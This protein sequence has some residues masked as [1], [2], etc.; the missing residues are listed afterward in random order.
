MSEYKAIESAFITCNSNGETG[1]YNV[2][3]K[4]NTLKEAQQV[5]REIIDIINEPDDEWISIDDR[6]PDKCGHN[7]FS[8]CVLAYIKDN[9]CQYTAYYDHQNE[10]WKCFNSGKDIYGGTITHWKPLP[11]PPK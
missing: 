11:E 8:R 1:D 9:L 3:L 10:C 4:I 7:Y 2:T 5:H 6:L